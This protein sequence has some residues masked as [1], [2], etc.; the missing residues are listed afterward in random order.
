MCIV[1]LNGVQLVFRIIILMCFQDFPPGRPQV[2]SRSVRAGFHHGCLTTCLSACH[3]CADGS[4]VDWPLVLG[5]FSA[6]M[7]FLCSVL[8]V[9]MVVHR[10]G[11]R[12]LQL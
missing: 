1:P 9:A 12:E 5:S 8:V 2:L 10:K 6:A 4:A 7:L 3:L 11:I